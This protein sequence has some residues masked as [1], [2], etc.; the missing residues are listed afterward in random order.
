MPISYRISQEVFSRVAQGNQLSNYKEANKIRR[1]LQPRTGG[2][3]ARVMEVTV[4]SG[5][6]Q[7]LLEV[8]RDTDGR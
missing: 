8:A 3:V 7:I 4:P 6:S 1:H 2:L 5:K